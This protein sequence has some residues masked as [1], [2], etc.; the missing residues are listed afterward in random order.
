MLFISYSRRDKEEV[1][2]FVEALKSTGV[3]VWIDRE[4]IDPLDDSRPHPRRFGALSRTTRVVFGRV[5]Q[6]E[7]LPKRADGSLDFQPTTNPRS[8]VSHF[9]DQSRAQRDT[10]HPRRSR[11]PELLDRS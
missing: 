10:Y 4:E 9:C 2:P 7:L 6:V 1:Y 5:R 8:W 11:P 3:Q